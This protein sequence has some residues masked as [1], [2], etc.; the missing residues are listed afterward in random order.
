L[1]P[2][3]RG[4]LVGLRNADGSRW[5]GDGWMLARRGGDSVA[6]GGNGAFAPSYGANQIGAVLRYRLGAASGHRLT[7][8]VRGY[9]AMNGSGEKEAAFGLSARPFSALPVAA[10]VEM[11]VSRFADGATH[12]RPAAPV[13]LGRGIE[14]ETY[15]QAGYVGGEA[16][17]GFV[18]GQARVEKVVTG[19]RLG[20]SGQG[21]LRVG[22]GAWG[23]AQDKVGRLD[24]GPSL[25]LTMSNGHAG[26]R[27]ALDWRMRVEGNAMPSS[28]PA[29]TLSA[30][31]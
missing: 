23:G 30:G 15:G 28:G 19:L 11:R 22:L 12:L 13:A 18:D 1:L 27:L 25:R 29:L 17:T 2:Q 3:T 7:A 31:F 16:A 26:A 24:M 10:L 14:L 8:Y 9:G 20:A 4:G 6:S 21:D 5:S